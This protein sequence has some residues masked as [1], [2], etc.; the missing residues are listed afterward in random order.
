MCKS[1]YLKHKSHSRTCNLA[2]VY[3]TVEIFVIDQVF[4]ST[5]VCFHVFVV[6]FLSVQTQSAHK[7]NTV[8]T[9]I[10]PNQY[11]LLL[12]TGKIIN[13]LYLKS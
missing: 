9:H 5:A 10:A 3:F 11:L 6:L 8:A 12:M 7:S 13:P 4:L 1:R 2:E